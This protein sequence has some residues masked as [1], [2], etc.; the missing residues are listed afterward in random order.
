MSTNCPSMKYW[1]KTTLIYKNFKMLK[2]TNSILL[3]KINLLCNFQTL[4]KKMIF[5]LYFSYFNQ[6][7][8]HF[9]AKPYLIRSISY[10]YDCPAL[11]LSCHK[12]QRLGVSILKTR[13]KITICLIFSSDRSV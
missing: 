13:S 11:L 10:F 8:L 2:D 9:M 5:S 6:I 7:D 4:I 3:V 1:G 12:R